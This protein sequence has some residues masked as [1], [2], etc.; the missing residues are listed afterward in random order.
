M[1]TSPVVI[2]PSNVKC[3][4]SISLRSS[5]PTGHPDRHDD[6]IRAAKVESMGLIAASNTGGGSVVDVDVVVGAA[7]VAAVASSGFAHLAGS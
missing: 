2:W 4:T 1:T 7:V 3:E 5:R 6:D